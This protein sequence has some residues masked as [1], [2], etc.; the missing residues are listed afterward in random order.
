LDLD[1]CREIVD[2]RDCGVVHCHLI[3]IERLTLEE[4]VPKFDLLYSPQT[5]REIER[6][7]AKKVIELVLQYDLAYGAEII[8]SS[9]AE[10]LAGRFLAYFEC[11]EAQYYTNGSWDE[12][13]LRRIWTPATTATFDA[14]ILVVG[15]SRAGCLWVEDE[16]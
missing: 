8:N 13:S 5:Y 14:G 4:L 6:K 10:D 16:D 3:K 7:K 9:Q 2:A 15:R 1:I 12:E 11:E